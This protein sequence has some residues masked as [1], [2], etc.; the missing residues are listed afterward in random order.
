MSRLPFRK[1]CYIS[2]NRYGITFF[3]RN[4]KGDIRSHTEHYNQGNFISLAEIEYFL[5]YEKKVNLIDNLR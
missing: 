3:Y 5:I 4:I 2:F 1:T